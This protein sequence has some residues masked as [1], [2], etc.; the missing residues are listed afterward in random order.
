MHYEGDSGIGC[1]NFHVSRMS[2]NMFLFVTYAT[3]WLLVQNIG[4]SG[5]LVF[6]EDPEAEG[7]LGSPVRPSPLHK[8]NKA[9]LIF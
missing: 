7:L 9:N 1:Y 2:I 8:A 6:E 4:T 3:Y 5:I